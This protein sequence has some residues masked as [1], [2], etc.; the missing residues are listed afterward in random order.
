MDEEDET[1]LNLN[2]TLRFRPSDNINQN[3]ERSKS[4]LSART[5][6]DNASLYSAGSSSG[7]ASRS[8][9][10][11]R[12]LSNCSRS[13][14]NFLTASGSPF[15]SPSPTCP[16]PTNFIR[17]VSPLAGSPIAFHSPPTP[18]TPVGEGIDV[19]SCRQYDAHIRE[20][21]GIY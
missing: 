5:A 18:L 14:L 7:R 6:A 21:R 8:P 10:S 17:P 12:R 3:L 19:S 4:P 11:Q 1:D 20:I 16:S 15:R 13:N 9:N 2:I